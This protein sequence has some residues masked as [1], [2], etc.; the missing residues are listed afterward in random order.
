MSI[1]KNSI[2]YCEELAVVA[3]RCRR[4]ATGWLLEQVSVTV[5]IGGETY[6]HKDPSKILLAS[7]KALST[8]V[9]VL[10]PSFLTRN[11]QFGS[12]GLFRAL[13]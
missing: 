12:F 5:Q 6:G 8:L 7:E 11:G 2:C 4:F 13:W 10:R 9:W 1:V 3:L